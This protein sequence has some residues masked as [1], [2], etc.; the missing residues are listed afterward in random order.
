MNRLAIHDSGGEVCPYLGSRD[1]PETALWYPSLINQCYRVIP[2]IPVKSKYQAT[3][4]LTANHSECRV[5]LED[6]SLALPLDQTEGQQEH[7]QWQRS[8]VLVWVIL[9]AIVILGVLIWLSFSGGFLRFANRERPFR[10]TAP[11]SL[12]EAGHPTLP[13]VPTR[14]QNTVTPTL[15]HSSPSPSRTV[16]TFTPTVRPFHG[17]ETPIGIDHPLIIHR[18][19]AGESLDSISEKFGTTPQ[20]LRLVNY[21]L[22]I[23]LLI[24]NLIIIPVNQTDVRGLPAFQAFMVE[25]GITVEALAKQVLVDPVMLEYYNELQAG[26]VLAAGEWVLVPHIS[27][28]TP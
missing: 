15:L 4:C 2:A 18:I 1:D 24:N 14:V 7:A 16:V 9:L 19:L 3:C 26:Q 22:V 27:T 21:N 10:E 11:L 5:Y 8:K 6:V 12:A 13:T 25:N 28:P 20:A 17:L 23:D